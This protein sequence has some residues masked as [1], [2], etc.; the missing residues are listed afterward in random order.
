MCCWSGSGPDARSSPSWAAAGCYADCGPTPWPWTTD[1]SSLLMMINAV[2]TG[3]F[4]CPGA[5]AGTT[6]PA[7]AIDP[8]LLPDAREWAW[9]IAHQGYNL[10]NG[11]RCNGRTRASVEASGNFTADLRAFGAGG[12]PASAVASWQAVA[13]ACTTVLMNPV[14]SV[15][16]VAVAHDPSSSLQ[17]AFVLLAR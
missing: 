17:T 16:N 1:E 8:A 14:L 2:R 3:G 10:A 9:E 5:G 11:N 12:T 13:G 7:L 15:A 6:A 4:L